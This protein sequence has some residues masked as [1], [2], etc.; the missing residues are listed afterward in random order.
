M[1]SGGEAVNPKEVA[2]RY[3]RGGLRLEA[4]SL[5]SPAGITFVEVSKYSD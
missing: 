5:F 3:G 2:D 4:A 1:E